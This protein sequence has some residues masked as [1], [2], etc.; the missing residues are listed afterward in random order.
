[1]STS[2][3]TNH[4]L[5]RRALDLNDQEAW[6]KLDLYY[7][8]FIYY[9][10]HQLRAK[11][12]DID[13][14]TQ[15]VMVLLMEK[16]SQYDPEKG[17]FRSWLK[18]VITN[19][20]YASL[21]KEKSETEKLSAFSE[22]EVLRGDMHHTDM[23]AFIDAEWENYISTLALERIKKSFH[24]NAVRVFELGLE[25]HKTSEIAEITG[26]KES[27]VYTLRKRVKKSLL[28]EIRNLA[29]QLES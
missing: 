3:K 6:K 19:V 5:L 1:M 18:K 25:G 27:S 7:R 8:R 20:T 11:P 15:Q 4:S 28:S 26:L 22:E 17:Q 16:L 24:G 13:D 2:G 14:L 10:L 29:A 23:E 9:I 12:S 21:R